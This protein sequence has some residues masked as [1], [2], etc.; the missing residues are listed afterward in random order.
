MA[1]NTSPALAGHLQAVLDQVSGRATLGGPVVLAALL[2]AAIGV[3]GQIETAFDRIWK[4]PAG[5]WRGISGAILN[6]LY[7]RLR[8]FLMLMGAGLVLAALAAGIAVS[9][10]RNLTPGIAAGGLAW[11]LAE[12]VLSAVLF[13]LFFTLLY[14]SLPKVRVRWSEAARAGLLAALLW[15]ATRQLLA[16]FFVGESYTAYGVVGSLIAVML[17]IYVAS[18]ILFLGAEHVRVLGQHRRGGAEPLHE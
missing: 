9:T 10:I 1:Q 3:F 16:C 14:K 12:I 2:L 17:W 15:E 4:S 5:G 7:Y 8:A 6:A 18:S 11:R 13:W